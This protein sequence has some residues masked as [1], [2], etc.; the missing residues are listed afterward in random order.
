MSYYWALV[1]LELMEVTNFPQYQ[2]RDGMGASGRRLRRKQVSEGRGALLKLL[3]LRALGGS[4]LSHCSKPGGH[5]PTPDLG[6]SITFQQR[7]FAGESRGPLRRQ[8]DLDRVLLHE[9]GALRRHLRL[10]CNEPKDHSYL[11][12]TCNDLTFHSHHHLL[13][14]LPLGKTTDRIMAP[15]RL[16]HPNPWNLHVNRSF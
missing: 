15:L 3:K 4:E 10:R 16:A 8:M 9:P 1:C 13:V 11:S 5:A 12:S 14:A 2:G 7:P 6:P